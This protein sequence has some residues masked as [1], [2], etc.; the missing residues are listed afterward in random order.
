MTYQSLFL[1]DTN[2]HAAADALREVAVSAGYQPFDPFSGIPG[3]AYAEAVRM[4]AAPAQGRWTRLLG[5]V[6][7]ALIPLLSER[8]DVIHARLEGSDGTISRWHGGVPIDLPAD[9]QLPPVSVPRQPESG[10]AGALP[11]DIQAMNAHPRQADRLIERLSG[12]VLAKAGGSSQHAA[13]QALLQSGERWDSPA[14]IR[15]ARVLAWLEI[16]GWREPDFATLRE[17]YALHARRH[18]RPN[19][20]LLPGDEATMTAIPNALDYVPVY[21]G[22]G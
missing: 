3:R 17:A 1:A 7:A 13:A 9:G 4:F 8:V 12:S 19:A 14:G 21:A 20:A 11:P 15:I 22:K 16:D 18:R 6:D 2:P 5:E 10:W